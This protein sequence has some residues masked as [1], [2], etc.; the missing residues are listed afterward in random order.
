MSSVQRIFTRYV[1]YYISG[2]S[3]TIGLSQDAEIDCLTEKG[4]RAGIIYFGSS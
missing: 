4:E 2:S 1:V 3:P